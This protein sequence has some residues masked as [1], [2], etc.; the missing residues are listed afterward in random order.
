MILP[1]LHTC[2]LHLSLIWVTN[3]KIYETL[4]LKAIRLSLMKYITNIERWALLT[5][6]TQRFIVDQ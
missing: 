1:M 3:D 4:I 6:F 5:I 2:K